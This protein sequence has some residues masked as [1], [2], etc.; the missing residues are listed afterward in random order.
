MTDS[1]EDLG[2]YFASRDA[3]FTCNEGSACGLAFKDV[4]TPILVS[5]KTDH[6]TTMY[7][8]DRWS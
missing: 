7:R 3:G 6:S 2:C 4:K 5:V 8:L 1:P